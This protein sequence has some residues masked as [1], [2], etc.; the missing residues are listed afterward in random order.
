[1][2][3]PLTTNDDI[4]DWL[5]WSI[6]ACVAI[7]TTTDNAITLIDMY[8]SVC[9]ALTEGSYIS[10]AWIGQPD[11][12]HTSAIN[13][14]ACS[15]AN[16]LSMRENQVP[17]CVKQGQDVIGGAFLTK[18]IQYKVVNDE[19]YCHDYELANNYKYCIAIPMMDAHHVVTAVLV[20][21][22]EN[23]HADEFTPF[24]LTFFHNIVDSVVRSQ[25]KLL[26]KQRHSKMLVDVV[27]A[28][29]LAH[30]T[31]DLYTAGHQYRV[32][33]LSAA[34][35]TQLGL[36]QD[37][38]LGTR[39]AALLHDIG[40]LNTP[41]DVLNKPSR[42]SAIEYM[43]VREH[44][45]IGYDIL[46]TVDFPWP[47][48]EAVYQHHERLDGRG[49]P[50]QLQGDQIILEARII[51]VADIV[52]SMTS[53]RPYRPALGMERAIEEITTLAHQGG[54]DSDVVDVCVN[55]LNNRGYLVFA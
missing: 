41:S 55:L 5:K 51:S 17:W 53:H 13:V 54:L 46:K 52:E 38:V 33:Q 11:N 50:R 29:S 47:I 49:Y 14:V 42:L 15:S 19:N 6:D 10:A 35:A 36:S 44:V 39:L 37:R 28:L 1:M 23:D 8:Q 20:A 3:Q 31:R 40:K 26:M 7:N 32:S 2:H 27:N 30:E 48:A 22:S 43:L 45:Q 18:S 24:A 4:I 12:V 16:N 9:D 21:Y 25:H 34:I